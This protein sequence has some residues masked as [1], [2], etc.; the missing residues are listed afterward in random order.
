MNRQEFVS[1]KEMQDT[2]YNLFLDVIFD[3]NKKIDLLDPITIKTLIYTTIKR[4]TTIQ[5]K[6]L[7]N[8][9]IESHN[10]PIIYRH[11]FLILMRIKYSHDSEYNE[12]L[13]NTLVEEL[14]NKRLFNV[15]L[16]NINNFY[17]NAINEKKVGITIE[18]IRETFYNIIGEEVIIN[19]LVSK[20]DLIDQEPHIYFTMSSFAIVNRII[21]SLEEKTNG[22]R[23]LNNNVVTADNCVD[24]YKQL[25]TALITIK[26]TII[27]M[28]LQK[29]QLDFIKASIAVNNS[30]NNTLSPELLQYKTS[31]LMAIVGNITN[32]SIQI[33][34]IGHFKSIIN[35]I[36]TYCIDAL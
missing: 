34:Q 13:L 19:N 33:S 28:K 26:D 1:E 2:F 8:K 22:I 32:L 16:D 17:N 9:N 10:I 18:T 25:F 36:I 12:V 15:M 6:T 30:L 24:E 5:L 35:D 7:T 31:E 3:Y 4:L 20:Q 23:L 11:M 29:E 21:N 27:K 14:I